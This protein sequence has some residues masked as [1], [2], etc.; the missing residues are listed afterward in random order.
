MDDFIDAFRR[1]DDGSWL[2]M[3]D[4]TL[5]GPGG[6]IQVLAGAR[7]ERGAFFMGVDLA[8]FLDARL[9]AGAPPVS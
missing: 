4:V 2:C 3:R 1:D 7:F 8:R 9:R 5:E 6:R